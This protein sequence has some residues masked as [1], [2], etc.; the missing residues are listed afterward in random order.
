MALSLKE[1]EQEA[2][3]RLRAFWAGSSLGRPALYVTVDNPDHRARPW[4]HP[5][6]GDKEKDLLPEWHAWYNDQSLNSTLFLAEAMP[7][8]SMRWGSLLVTVAVLAGGEYEYHSN[9]AW[10]RPVADLWDW[11]LPRFEPGGPVV[12]QLEECTRR[13]AEVVGDRAY[14]N[15]QVM[16]DGLTTLSLFRTPEQLC[17]EVLEC[18]DLVR[19]WSDALTT[20]YID[21]YEHFYQLVREL[22]YGDTCAWLQATAE[23]RFEAVQCDFAVML[24]PA[25]FE[26]FALPDLRRLTDY[27][28]YS[29]Y[30]LDGTCQLRFLDLLG[31]LP[32]LNGIQWN[33]EPGAGSPADWIDAFRA[34]RQRGFCLY[35]SCTVDEAL[36]I[37]RALGPDGLM[38]VLPRFPSHQEA[39]EAIQAIEKAC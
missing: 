15:P 6:L 18:P 22:G 7:R 9:S 8:V 24:S 14:V 19:R 29:L 10:V 16:L 12:A 21:A 13:L 26:R 5:E 39:R 4:P 28:D 38:L 30:H 1:D 36:R 17:A 20:L 23:G 2:R 34:I 11:P 33:P 3:Q 37:T 32:G 27:L 35:L 31:E 25:M